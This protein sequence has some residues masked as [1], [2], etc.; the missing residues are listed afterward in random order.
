MNVVFDFGAVLFHWQPAQLVRQYFP[1]Q[2]QSDE[3]AHDLARDIF[4]HPDW[5]AFDQGLLLLPDVMARTV[6][7][8][9]LPQDGVHGLMGQIG[10]RLTPITETLTVLARL[11]HLRDAGHQVKAAPLR[12]YYLSNMPEPYA[13]VLAQRHPFLQ[14]FDGGVFSGD[15]K[16][17]KP[18]PAV[19]QHLARQHDLVAANTVF[20]DDLLG[21]V[22]AARALGWSGI[23]F[24]NA[25]QLTTD[26]AALGLVTEA[27]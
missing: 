2:V 11:R 17:I 25:A 16:L 3:T 15:V 27:V 10:E 12:L 8:L 21:N 9:G 4:H 22:E 19:F 20:I 1:Q 13:R 7:R 14:W 5:Q 6:T 18:D 24:Q 26:L 23:H